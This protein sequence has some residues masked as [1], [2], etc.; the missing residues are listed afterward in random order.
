MNT[1]YN[2][3]QLTEIIQNRQSVF[4]GFYSGEIIPE[5]TIQWILKNA[6]QA[7]SH[8]K[9]Y[10]WRFRV[11]AG[12]KRNELA[13]YFQTTYK[14][15]TPEEKYSEKKYG[16]FAKKVMATSHILVISM[17]EDPEKPLPQWEN[18]AAVA[19][20][21]QNIY[22]SVTAS[23]NAGYWSSPGSMIRNI[24][25]FVEMGE[26]ETCLGFFYIGVPKGELLPVN[27][28]SELEDFV[29]WM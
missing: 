4:P 24:D 19:C 20:A 8:R 15:N 11:V 29:Q 22:L 7:P 28:K 13:S 23:G 18:V 3:E 1:T 25:Q 26:N 10:P 17:V 12:D 6:I 27:A 16:D 14:A 2:T 21:V 5:E 9:I